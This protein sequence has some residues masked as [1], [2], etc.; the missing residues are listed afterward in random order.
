M[1][2][3]L[4]ADTKIRRPSSGK[5]DVLCL[6]AN[7]WRK[8]PDLKLSGNVAAGLENKTKPQQTEERLGRQTYAKLMNFH[9]IKPTNCWW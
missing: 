4:G 3:C 9:V 7:I 5:C 1:W 2:A 8:R 6:N